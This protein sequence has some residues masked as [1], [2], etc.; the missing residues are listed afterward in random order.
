MCGVVCAAAALAFPGCSDNDDDPIFVPTLDVSP[1]ELKFDE[2]GGA[3][4][5]ES[6][7]TACGKSRVPRD[8]SGW[9]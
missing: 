7:A 1:T 8:R 9:R 4:T 2:K 3:K 6:C 5:F